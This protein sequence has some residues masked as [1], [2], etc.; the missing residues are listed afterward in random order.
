M[1]QAEF[2]LRMS[3]RR[4]ARAIVGK[5]GRLAVPF[6]EELAAVCSSYMRRSGSI[7]IAGIVA[8]LMF[9][10]SSGLQAGII[11][12]GDLL[13]V[14]VDNA[15]RSYTTSGSLLQTLAITGLSA[16]HA[17]TGVAQGVSV[18]GDRLFVGLVSTIGSFTPKIVE[19]D[20]TTGSVINTLDTATPYLT[21]LGDDGR[22]LLLLHS[23]NDF[24]VFTHKTDGTFV[25]NVALVR[26]FAGNFQAEGIDG[27]GTSIFIS[28]ASGNQPIVTN[29][30][31]TGAH[32]S[33]FDTGMVPIGNYIGGLTYDRND[34]TLWVAG[35]SEFR[36]YTQAGTLLSIV[37]TGLGNT[38]VTGLEVISPSGVSAVPEPCSILLLGTGAVGLI[39]FARR[40][41]RKSTAA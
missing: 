39:G 26:P 24:R 32:V 21:G 23:V 38:S 35:N 4:I 5:F 27:D 30:A 19:V 2:G 36:H 16:E 7:R 40:G 6:S 1:H 33:Y 25:S 18:L 20:P 13:T 31:T 11:H 17:P 10:T 37:S 8:V 34:G 28:Y 29:T 3:N 14:S 15:L 9:F 12:S 22:N 41:R